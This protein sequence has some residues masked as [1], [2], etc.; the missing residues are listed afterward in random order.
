MGEPGHSLDRARDHYRAALEI[1][2]DDP[3]IWALLGRIDKD[4]WTAA[5]R[6]PNRT[7][8]QKRDDAA[9]DDAL[10]DA[11]IE[12]YG[13]GYRANQSHYYSGINALTLMHLQ[14]HLI[15]GKRTVPELATMAGAVRF[16]AL[17]EESFWAKVTLGDLE[18]LTGTPDSI[19]TAYKKA[20][21]L[22]EKDWFAL[23]SS[24]D[25]L[26]LLR[27]LGF[28]PDEVEA[29]IA[30][31]ERALQGLK[32]P[33]DD[34]E[35]NQVFL[36]SGHMIDAPDRPEPRFPASKEAAARQK[37]EAALDKHGASAGDLAF[38]QAAAGG[39]LL[40]VEACLQR[41]VRCQI[42]LPFP[43][44]EFIQNSVMRSANGPSWRDRFYAATNDANSKVR[45]MP[46]ELGPP[47]KDVDP[48]ERCNM[49][50]LYSALSYGVKKVRFICLWNGAIGDGKGGTKHLY[51]EAQRLTGRVDWIDTREL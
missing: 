46:D 33:E 40:F 9:Y 6:R 41:G 4:A 45:I 13:K 42:L 14:Q 12:S 48:Y 27:E 26:V 39:D 19:R 28:R 47:P 35:P 5:W 7:P 8:E 23:E 2:P 51:D 25:Q 49:W 17:G 44:P 24:R 36:F 20:I 43:E 31:F 38:A 34:W 3:E 18:V 16:A 1:Y 22:N 29:G 10:L 50:L 32:K 11:A 37:I 15:P 21:A 30:T